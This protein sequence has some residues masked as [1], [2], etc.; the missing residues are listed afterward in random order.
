MAEPSKE[1]TELMEL[2][3]RTDAKWR[4]LIQRAKSSVSGPLNVSQYPKPEPSDIAK[5]ID[6]TLLD[7]SATQDQIDALCAEAKEYGFAAVCVRLEWV[8][9]AVENLKGTGIPVACVIGFH[10]GTHPIPEMVA[11]A[12]TALEKGATELDMVINYPFLRSGRYS[13][14]FQSVIMLRTSTKERRPVVKLKVI[15]ETS[16]LSR[17]DIIAGCVLSCAAGVNFVKTSTGFNGAG[18]TVENVALMRAV[19]E[20]CSNGAVEI[21]ASGGIR[22]ADDCIKMIQAGATRIGASSGIKIVKEALGDSNGE[23]DATT[24]SGY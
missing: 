21:K 19:V 3:S 22:T 15:L 18:A 1:A 11:E 24:A 14:A 5:A 17:D 20:S 2:I 13:D 23:A 10:E 16:Q 7:Q 8:T 4:V 12:R 9:R 6:H